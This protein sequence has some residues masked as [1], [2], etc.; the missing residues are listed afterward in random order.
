MALTVKRVAQLLRQGE[1]GRHLDRG[2]PRGLYL[3]ISSPNA[4][5]W[6]LRYQL[7]GRGH[8]LGLGSARDFSLDEAR[9]RARRERQRLADGVDPLAAR[10]ADRAARISAEIATI[11]FGEAAEKFFT[12]HAPSWRSRHHTIQWAATV[13]GRTL[14]GTPATGDYCATLRPLPVAIIDIPLILKVLEKHWHAKPET[15]NRV[16]GRIESVLDWAKARGLRAGDNPA[17]WKTIGKVLPAPRKVATVQHFLAVPYADL[18]AFMS[19]LSK[20]EGSAARALEI[21]ILTASRTGEVLQARWSEIDLDAGL[22]T[23]PGE[24]MK[25]GREHVVPLVDRAVEILRTLPRE[26]GNEFIFIGTRPGRG[27]GPAA[28][29]RVMARM[30]RRESVHGFRSTFSDWGHERTAFASHEIEMSLA[31]S[32]GSAVERSYRRGTLFDKRRRLM[33]AWARFCSSPA[34]RQTKNVVSLQGR[35]L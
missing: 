13:L 12:A 30:G 3:S 15:M 17:A 26:A 8:W 21:L 16:R 19:D 2:G 25:S 14:R 27:L 18:P 32:V 9:S 34:A 24:R 4:A 35:I 33:K 6:E 7:R 5:H 29:A 10:R 22:W 23:V 11:T 1:P 28:L 20:Q 31:H